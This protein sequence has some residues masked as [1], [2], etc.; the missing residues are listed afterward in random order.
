MKMNWRIKPL[1]A[2]LETENVSQRIDKWLWAR[3]FKTRPLA[4]EA[5]EGG[6]VRVNDERVKPARNAAGSVIKF[7]L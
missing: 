3:F 4:V 7:A 2:I 6:H 5:I 1:H